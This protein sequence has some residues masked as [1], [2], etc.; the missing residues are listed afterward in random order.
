MMNDEARMTNDEDKQATARCNLFVIRNSG[1]VIP[2]VS[3]WCK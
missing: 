1:F 2:A 3:P